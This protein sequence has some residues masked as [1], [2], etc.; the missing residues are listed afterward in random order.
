MNHT[1]LMAHARARH[2]FHALVP[3]VNGPARMT[4]LPCYRIAPE[5]REDG[6]QRPP[7]VV[8]IAY[9]PTVPMRFL[10]VDEANDVVFD[11]GEHLEAVPLP[12]WAVKG[13]PHHGLARQHNEAARADVVRI[14]STLTGQTAFFEAVAG[15]A[16]LGLTMS[17][18]YC[19][20][21]KA[22]QT[23]RVVARW[24]GGK[25]GLLLGGDDLDR[26][27]TRTFRIDRISALEI[28]EER[29]PVWDGGWRVNR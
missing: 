28:L 8:C 9:S 27:A 10:V 16:C 14:P 23:R 7:F 5:P 3:T 6:S 13:H 4:L 29:L 12:W 24:V 20:P 1:T 15:A 21:G 25:D 18:G 11:D 2:E 22:E 26:G 17:F 19:K